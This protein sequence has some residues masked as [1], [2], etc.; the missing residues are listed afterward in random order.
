MPVE[1]RK[2]SQFWYGRWRRNGRRKSAR[3]HVPI[4]GHPG[5]PEFLA[6]RQEAEQELAKLIREHD[7]RQRPEEFVQQI[8]ELRFGSRVGSIPLARIFDQWTALPR[9]REPSPGYRRFA[10]STVQQFVAYVEANHKGIDEMAGVTAEMAEAFMRTQWERGVSPKTYNTVLTLLRGV[11]ERLR[12]KAGLLANPFKESLV[13]RDSD[14]IH[15]QPFTVEELKHLIAVAGEHDPGVQALI[16]I[17]ACTALRLGDACCLRWDDVDLRRSRISVK[18]RKTGEKVAIPILGLLRTVLEKLPRNGSPFVL[19]AF[20]EAY[21]RCRSDVHDRLRKVFVL[22]GF[23]GQEQRPDEA[24]GDTTATI[25][26]PSEK[27]MRS[28]VLAHIRS[29]SEAEVAPRVK[30]MMI[31]T[32][33][34][35]SSGM[36]LPDIARELDISKGSV[37]N[38]LKRIEALSGHPIIRRE[39]DAAREGR[40]EATAAGRLGRTMQREPRQGLRKVN[41]RG[42]HA[43]RATFTTQALESGLPVEIVKLITGHTLTETVIRHY[44]NPSEKSVF[45]AVSAAMP[46]LL[47]ENKEPDLTERM[48]AI[49]DKATAKTWREAM[50]ELRLIATELGKRQEVRM[51]PQASHGATDGRMN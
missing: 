8:H 27:D 7:R 40:T 37:W 20:A 35:Y 26:I 13:H 36:T 9:K 22:A 19:P 28:S 33:D 50:S 49:I 47:T 1:T 39:V 15:R 11:F 48:I 14:S 38:Y 6:S 17:G 12:V 51:T 2:T 5:S 21:Q 44:F 24:D 18:T 25:D 23:D 3:L 31:R 29:M 45:E 10:E 42:F 43:L 32:Y 30:D 16:T 34:L 46:R 4:V 41:A